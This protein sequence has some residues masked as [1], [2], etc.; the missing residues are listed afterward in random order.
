VPAL[1]ALS[2]EVKTGEFYGFLGANGA[3]KSTTIRLLLNFIQP[4]AGTATIMGK[5]VERANVA[6][7]K[8]AGDQRCSG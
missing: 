2:L 5:D 4:T 1:D 8:H 3:G 6:V 7:K